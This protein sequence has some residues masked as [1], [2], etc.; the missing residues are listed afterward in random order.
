MST[1]ANKAIVRRMIHEVFAG[2]N[3]A[4]L[5]ELVAPNFVNHNVVGTGEASH[6]EGIENF[7]EEIGAIHQAMPDVQYDIIH[8][9]ADGDYVISHVQGYGTYTGEFAGLAPTGQKI[10]TRSISIIRLANGRYA[11]RW[12]LVDRYGTMQ[13]L[14]AIPGQ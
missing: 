11:E 13:Q 7:R 2:G 12:N 6:S 14:G 5:D 9:L 10:E 1:E 3:L 8:L 4:L